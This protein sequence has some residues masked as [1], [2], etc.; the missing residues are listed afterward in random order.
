MMD[1]EPDAPASAPP[2]VRDT[3]PLPPAPLPSDEPTNTEPLLPAS[4]AELPLARMTEPPLPLPP[5]P[6]V[7]DTLPPP[8]APSPADTDKLPPD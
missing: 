3:S 6:P 1:N 2:L 8:A 5:A 4:D 7:S